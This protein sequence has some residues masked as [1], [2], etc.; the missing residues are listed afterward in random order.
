MGYYKRNFK[1]ISENFK[2]NI[3]EII[4]NI[5]KP[6]IGLIDK[7]YGRWLELNQ[8]LSGDLNLDSDITFMYSSIECRT[9]YLNSKLIEKMLSIDP[10]KF[11][12]KKKK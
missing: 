7:N 5:H 11:S 3:Q 2:R 12:I 8:Y 4:K 9:P 10:D 1:K 6:P